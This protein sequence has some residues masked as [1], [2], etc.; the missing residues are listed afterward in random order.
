MILHSPV[1]SPPIFLCSKKTIRSLYNYSSQ[2]HIYQSHTTLINSRVLTPVNQVFKVMF[3]NIYIIQ[4]YYL[5]FFF[6]FHNFPFLVF[7]H[8][9]L[10]LFRNCGVFVKEQISLCPSLTFLSFVYI[11]T[12]TS[13]NGM[14]SHISR[15]N[16]ICH[17]ST[18]LT[19]PLISSCTLKHSS[20]ASFY[21]SSAKLFIVFTAFK[22]NSL[23]LQEAVD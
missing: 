8:L 14:T 11:F 9:D 23:I 6:N 22:P 13:P 12:C 5:T 7:Y 15:F 1:K 17:F 16:C 21:A 19:R 2:S 10:L 3:R 20:S 4:I 18:Q